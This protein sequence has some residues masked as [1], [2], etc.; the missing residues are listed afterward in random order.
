MREP[1]KSLTRNIRVAGEEKNDHPAAQNRRKNLAV[2]ND[3]VWLKQRKP[4]RATYRAGCRGQS[5]YG[6]SGKGRKGGGRQALWTG[7]E[8]KKRKKYLVKLPG[9]VKPC[10]ERGGE[11]GGLER[12]LPTPTL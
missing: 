1:K 2:G 3:R 9:E 12:R 4:K 6:N 8:E 10:G 7:G 11:T 5:G